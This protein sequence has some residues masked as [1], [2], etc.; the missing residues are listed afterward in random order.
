M[1]INSEEEQKDEPM[2]MEPEVN[3]NEDPEVNPVEGPKE[4]LELGEDQVE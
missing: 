1:V 3:P 4:K 2:E